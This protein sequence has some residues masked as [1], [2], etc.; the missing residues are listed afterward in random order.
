M[1]GEGPAG[2]QGSGE[3]PG[4][5]GISGEG[6]K[7]ALSLRLWRRVLPEGRAEGDLRSGTGET[8]PGTG[9]IGRKSHPAS[10][11]PAAGLPRPE[12]P[13]TDPDQTNPD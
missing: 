10:T 6:Q 3:D 9:E 5:P 12:Q 11:E 2:I 4:E 7:D 13:E 1:G 8:V